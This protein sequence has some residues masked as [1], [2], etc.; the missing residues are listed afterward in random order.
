MR[1]FRP[2]GLPRIGHSSAAG[3][4]SARKRNR[5]RSR[6]FISFSMYRQNATP[7]SLWKRRSTLMGLVLWADTGHDTFSW[8]S[9]SLDNMRTPA[10]LKLLQHV[11]TYVKY[12]LAQLCADTSA[13]VET[14][15]GMPSAD[16][17]SM[18]SKK[19][20]FVHISTCSY[21]TKRLICIYYIQ[22][23]SYDSYM[24]MY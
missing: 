4:Q 17:R 15:D 7:Y 3:I 21:V 2:R 18:N 12:R 8:T 10:V 19:P 1:S 20:R 6:T 22:Y 9:A 24:S 14:T 13:K 23:Y 16:A 5:K 11:L